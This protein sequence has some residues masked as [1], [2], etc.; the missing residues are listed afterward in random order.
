MGD[1]ETATILGPRYLLM[2]GLSLGVTT[3]TAQGSLLMVLK[4]AYEMLGF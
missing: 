3:S 4:G 1:S 2:V